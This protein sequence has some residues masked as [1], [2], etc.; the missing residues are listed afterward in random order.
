MKI[1]D[2]DLFEINE[3]SLLRQFIVSVLTDD[4][5]NVM[6]GLSHSDTHWVAPV[7]SLARHSFTKWSG[8]TLSSVS[9]PCA[10]AVAWGLRVSLS[11]PDSLTS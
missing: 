10:S 4:R 6:A 7:P 11:A 3:A 8:V 9:F 5:I 1:D 2:I